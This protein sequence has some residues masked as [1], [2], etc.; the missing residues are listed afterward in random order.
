MNNEL[1]KSILNS[2]AYPTR[3]EVGEKDV[4]HL[5]SISILIFTC[6]DPLE[7]DKLLSSYSLTGQEYTIH[8]HTQLFCKSHV[9]DCYV[10]WGGVNTTDK[11][12]HESCPATLKQY[13]I[14]L[15]LLCYVAFL[16][17]FY[18]LMFLNTTPKE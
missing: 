8:P 1:C 5:Q 12:R 2:S 17:D 16:Q 11:K 14:L 4:S 13:W 15:W 7:K 6:A 3:A 10:V 9:S 18:M